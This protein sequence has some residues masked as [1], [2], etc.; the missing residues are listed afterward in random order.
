MIL[1]SSLI[2][3]G[4]NTDCVV[5]N[6]KIENNNANSSTGFTGYFDFIKLIILHERNHTN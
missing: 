1:V 2:Y 4:Y 5:Q 6:F 3:F